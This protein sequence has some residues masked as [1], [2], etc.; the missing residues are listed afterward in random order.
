MIP[1]RNEEKFIARCLDSILTISYPL[2]NIEVFVCDG[3]SDDNSRNIIEGYTGGSNSKS[4]SNRITLLDNPSKTTQ[5]A[6]NLGINRSSGDFIIILGAHAELD[7]DY[8]TNCLEAFS[9]DDKLGCVGGVIENIYED[10]Q[11]KGIGYAM[12][13]P[14]GVGNAFFRTG[15]KEGYVDTVAFGMY[16]KEVFDKIG[17]FDEELVR[18]QDDEFNFRLTKSGYK[19]YLSRSIR[20]KYY[21]RSSFVKL[22]R[23]YYQYGYWKVFVNKKHKTITTLRQLIP[24]LF[25]SWL[26]LGGVLS[27]IIPEIWVLYILANSLYF[28]LVILFGLLKSINPMIVPS[29]WLSFFILHISYGLGYLEGIWQ[30]VILNNAPKKKSEQLTR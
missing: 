28:G 8:I 16:K 6:L 22:F 10:N 23:Q 25:V 5:H 30:F 29:I 14:F 1:C 11:S 27:L 18:N 24:F 2:D 15:K 3:M 26:I 7:Y 17:L 20:S 13:S 21:V 12:S 19:I 9:K 4:E